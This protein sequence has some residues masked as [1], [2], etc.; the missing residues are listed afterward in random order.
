[1]RPQ[2]AFLGD[3]DVVQHCVTADIVPS[4]HLPP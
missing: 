3:E 2:F 4:G 1:M